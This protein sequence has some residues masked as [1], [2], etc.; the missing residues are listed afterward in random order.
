MKKYMEFK[1]DLNSYQSA[2][3]FAYS[4]KEI[5]KINS[6]KKCY[7]FN[8]KICS[9]AFLQSSDLIYKRQVWTFNLTVRDNCTRKIPNL[10]MCFHIRLFH[11]FSII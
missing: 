5:V 10:I 9:Y 3:D 6:T 11:V 7:L 8:L 2:A 4:T 1:N